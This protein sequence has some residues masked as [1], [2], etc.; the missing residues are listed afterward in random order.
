MAV[1]EPRRASVRSGSAIPRQRCR[2]QTPHPVSSASMEVP[3]FPASCARMRRHLFS[4]CDW[5]TDPAAGSS[6][7][8][9]STAHRAMVHRAMARRHRA[10]EPA[11][12]CSP[13]RLLGLAHSALG[14]SP[15]FCIKP[16]YLIAK[17][18]EPEERTGIKA[19]QNPSSM[20]SDGN[21]I[22]LAAH[23]AP[24]NDQILLISRGQRHRYAAYI[25]F[26]ARNV[27]CSRRVWKRH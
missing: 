7:A 19:R 26:P 21:T 1:P 2:P 24:N 6:A 25:L 14:S 10:L 3:A 27:S 8:R 16:K 4:T 22:N 20:T 17:N 9:H 15:C 13:P 12:S 11:H 5:D 23:V 18:R